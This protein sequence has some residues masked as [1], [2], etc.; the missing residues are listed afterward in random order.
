MLRSTKQTIMN[1]MVYFM[2]SFTLTLTH[3]G[4]NYF[5]LRLVFFV[6]LHLFISS[7]SSILCEFR[8]IFLY[9]SPVARHRLMRLIRAA[10]KLLWRTFQMSFGL[11]A[12]RIVRNVNDVKGFEMKI[13]LVAYKGKR[14]GRRIECE[15]EQWPALLVKVIAPTL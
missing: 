2:K 9:L 7:K 4:L 14:R 6:S 15:R 1:M 5:V 8:V 3:T 11:H 10:K 13:E 12:V